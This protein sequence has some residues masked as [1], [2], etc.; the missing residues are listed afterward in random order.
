[1]VQ[2]FDAPVPQVVDQLMDMLTR[3]DILVLEQVIEVPKIS[4]PSRPH[5][6]VLR[7]PQTAEHL[8]VPTVVSFSSLQQQIAEQNI[9]PSV[10]GRGV[11]GG[12]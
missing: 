1:M 6:A 10:P 4:C 9:D 3:F 8:D 12:L 11:S 2:I 7:E 5:R